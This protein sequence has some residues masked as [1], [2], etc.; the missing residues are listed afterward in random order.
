M[1]ILNAS[2]WDAFLK[3]HPEAHLLQNSA[4]GELKSDFGWEVIHVRV[5]NCG[6]Q[7]LFKALPLGFRVAYIP[8]GPVGKNWN[9]LW[10][11]LH[12]ICQTKKV[13][14][15][16]VDPDAWEDSGELISSQM[17][18][19]NKVN[20]TI[21]PR[22][23]I[24]VSLDGSEEAWLDRMKQKTRYNIRLAQR[25]EVIVHSSNDVQ[26]FHKM[27]LLTGSRDKFGVHSIEY[28]QRA[29]SLFASLGLCN[30]LQADVN[31]TPVAGLM[32]FVFGKRS[33]YFYGASTDEAR[34]HMPTYLL[35]FEAMRWAAQKGASEY[36]L[37]GVPDVDESKLEENFSNKSDGLWG[38][39]RFKRGFGGR[40][41]RSVPPYDYVY[42]PWLYNFY[43]L[44]M[45]NRVEG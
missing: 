18:G 10:P 32:A 11:E 40:L 23:T 15:L 34:N 37:W 2:E 30:L 39:Y 45:G 28:Y 5:E 21:Q 9:L 6:A 1:T 38:V 3:D 7:V 36:D 19:F 27:M 29:Y 35:Q 42:I 8:K 25:K 4:W 41:L 33:W 26:T 44:W 31:G 43:L 24:V 20:R 14:F 22:R 16:K 13:V 12:H 17:A